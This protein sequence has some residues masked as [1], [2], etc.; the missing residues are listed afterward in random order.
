MNHFILL[1]TTAITLRQ[2]AGERE[3]S[4]MRMKKNA[5]RKKYF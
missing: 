5:L 2:D 3:L 1:A 4:F